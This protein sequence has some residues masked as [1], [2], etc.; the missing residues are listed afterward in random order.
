MEVNINRRTVMRTLAFYIAKGQE[1]MMTGG[2]IRSTAGE[3]RKVNLWAFDYY[4][5]ERFSPLSK[6]TDARIKSNKKAKETTSRM[7]NRTERPYIPTVYAKPDQPRNTMAQRIVPERNDEGFVDLKLDSKIF[8]LNNKKMFYDPDARLSTYLPPETY[9]VAIE[10]RRMDLRKIDDTLSILGIRPMTRVQ[11]KSRMVGGA[12]N[13]GKKKPSDDRIRLIIN[14]NGVFGS[15]VFPE[16]KES[17]ATC[18]FIQS[19]LKNC[20]TLRLYG[21]N[22]KL[23]S[24]EFW[25]RLS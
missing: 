1:L 21:Q 4:L 11:I 5:R 23:V 13:K 14:I 7:I 20:K 3:L 6:F 15:I 18:K 2:S 17:F 9:S 8:F 19:R 16:E 22:K 24:R 12:G 10:H 25:D